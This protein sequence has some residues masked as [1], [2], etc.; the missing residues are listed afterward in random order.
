MT[1]H[2]HKWIGEA[3]S[4]YLTQ[5]N[6]VVRIVRPRRCLAALRLTAQSHKYCETFQH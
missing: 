5:H 2:G 6:K 4:R 3:W 1:H